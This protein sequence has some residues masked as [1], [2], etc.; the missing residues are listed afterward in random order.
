[1]KRLLDQLKWYL[2]IAFVALVGGAWIH[3]TRI[4]AEEET[5]PLT[6]A[7]TDFT[8]PDIILAT[9]DGKAQSLDELRGKIVLIN[10][11]ASWCP[12]CRTEMPEIQAAVQAHRDTFVVLAINNRESGE[13]AQ[14]MIDELHLSFPVLLDLDGEAA[15]AYGV[16]AL[17]TSF[18][19]D[20]AGI[21]RAVN[22][23]GMNRAFIETQL[24]SLE[25]R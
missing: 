23:G 4:P 10:F 1:M 3:I 13:V 19:V 15:S 25:V 18:F 20:R 6:T 2:L 14:A 12:P 16:M 5:V 9:L 17:P 22:I 21:I 7:H 24:K 8:A 11:W